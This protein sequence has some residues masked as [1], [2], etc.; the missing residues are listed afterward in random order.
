MDY[1]ELRITQFAETLRFYGDMRFKQLTLF[2]G[3]MTAAGAGVAQFW[4]LR[5]LIAI[6]GMAVTAV[7]WTMEVRSTLYWRAL[8][9]K[10]PDLWPV[11]KTGCFGW[12]SA[13]N[14]VLFL[15]LSFYVF[16]LEC[17]FRWKPSLLL[18]V[19]GTAVV[20][21]LVDFSVRSYWRFG[22]R[23]AGKGAGFPG[24]SNM[25][26]GSLQPGPTGA[27]GKK[28]ISKW[29]V[30]NSELVLNNKWAKVRRD[31]CELPNGSEIDD[32]Y[33]WEG[34]DFAIIF[35]LTADL[36]VAVVRQY[37][38]GVKEVVSELPAGMI[39]DSDGNPLEAAKRELREE[40]GCEAKEWHP[41]GL[42]NVS[43]AKATTKAYAF[44]ALSV[45]QVCA[46][47]L[48]ET[49]EIQVVYS[50]FSSVLNQIGTGEFRDSNSI[51]TC[52]LALRQLT[53]SDTTRA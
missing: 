15:Y 35:A 33:Y 38:H 42:L 52:L 5:V 31:C 36:K 30:V 23:K 13:T 32:Y 9:E 1:E 20:S 27:P 46:P 45:Q 10:Y 50:P 44:L 17:A 8:W 14:V 26:N 4:N 2:I 29:R 53:G 22:G 28:S 11:P 12:L 21:L 40:T 39:M 25:Q 47:R 41:L 16:W 37:K 19:P 18:L 48:D 49:E 43:S 24:I 3:A 51:A 7:M 34:G 6:A